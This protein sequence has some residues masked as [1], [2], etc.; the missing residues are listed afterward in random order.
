MRFQIQQSIK[1][2]LIYTISCL[3][4]YDILVRLNTRFQASTKIKERQLAW[5]YHALK[6]IIGLTT[7]IE[8]WLL[9]WD[10]STQVQEGQSL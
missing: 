4:T 7:L 9:S 6:T 8:P 3:T 5:K 10:N 2:F 1:D